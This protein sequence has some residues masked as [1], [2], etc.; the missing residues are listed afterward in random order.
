ML[1][2]EEIAAVLLTE[3]LPLTAYF[4]NMTR[5]FHLAEDVFQEVCAKAVA[6]AGEF[7]SVVQVVNWA[8]VAGRNRAI[9][10]LRS[11]DGCHMG[12]S[13]ELLA[14]L[15][16]EWP[17]RAEVDA[18]HGAL[19]HCLEELKPHN[20]ELLRLRYF[21]QRRCAEVAERMGRKL[22]TVYQALARLHKALGD[23]VRGRLKD[24]QAWA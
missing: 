22:E 23:C 18:M 12:L 6:R 24:E 2:P 20:R 9:D 14:V 4:A 17:L 5:D 13:D 8:R 3:R 11:R 1:Y 15:A 21:E 7:E 19:E 16:E 10:I